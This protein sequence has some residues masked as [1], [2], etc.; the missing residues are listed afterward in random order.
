M[1]VDKYDNY[2]PKFMEQLRGW[3]RVDICMTFHMRA[4]N[5]FLFHCTLTW[6][7]FQNWASMNC[8]RNVN[9]IQPTELPHKFS[10]I[11]AIFIHNH[12]EAPITFHS[13]FFFWP[14]SRCRK[15]LIPPYSL[16]TTRLKWFDAVRK[17]EQN[18]NHW[19]RDLLKRELILIFSNRQY[20]WI[21]WHVNSYQFDSCLDSSQF[22]VLFP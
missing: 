1:V 15:N 3:G 8:P 9:S 17:F 22:S 12:F 5:F 14:K 4:F 6:Q 19:G 21:P 13:C 2:V 18:S 20:A 11:V 16:L 10:Y 7:I